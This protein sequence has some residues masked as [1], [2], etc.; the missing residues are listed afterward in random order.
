MSCDKKPLWKRALGWL[1]LTIA[2]VIVG[3]F[4]TF[5]LSHHI[6]PL[7]AKGI[8]SL[9]G[10]RCCFKTRDP[11]PV[12]MFAKQMAKLIK[13]GYVISFSTEAAKAKIAPGMYDCQKTYLEVTKNVLD[14]NSG[15]LQ[16]TIDTSKKV[17]HIY[18]SRHK[19]KG[20]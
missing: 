2:S 18:P 17:I 9:T 20:G 13:S 8:S 3:S 16:Y 15:N 10:K 4:V 5:S 12:E 11:I 14:R 7:W 1:A 19:K 6:Y